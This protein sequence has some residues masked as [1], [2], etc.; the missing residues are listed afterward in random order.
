MKSDTIVLDKNYFEFA[1]K[2]FHQI[3]GTAIGT[4]MA[5]SYANIFMDVLETN[6]LATQTCKPLIWKRYIDDILAIWDGPEEQLELFLSELNNYHQTIKFTHSTSDTSI[7]FLDST[8]YKGKRFA[9]DATL[10]IKPTFKVTN[11]FQYLHYSSAH[12]RSVFRGIIKGE[13][14]RVL[15]ASSD[16]PTYHTCH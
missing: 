7:N 16:K 15:R 6:F 13:A 3:Q 12:P 11:C 8:I 10:Y 9:T 1:G 2:K 14:T 5:P 4:K